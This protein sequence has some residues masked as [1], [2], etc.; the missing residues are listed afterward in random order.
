MSA[1]IVN[2]K[3]MTGS[4]ALISIRSL[5]ST[6]RVTHSRLL[7]VSCSHTTSNARYW[8]S[9]FSPETLDAMLPS[10]AT[11]AVNDPPYVPCQRELNIIISILS[12]PSSWTRPARCS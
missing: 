8:L 4:F 1:R 6:D 9:V 7:M 12:G 11:I 5:L 10:S 2:T 3:A